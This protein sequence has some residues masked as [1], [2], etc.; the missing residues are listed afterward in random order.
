MVAW[1]GLITVAE[2]AAVRDR[3]AVEL[4]RRGAG[5]A[6]AVE[7]VGHLLRP[8]VVRAVL[9]RLLERGVALQ[10]RHLRRSREV[11][12]VAERV[13]LLVRVVSPWSTAAVWNWMNAS[14]ADV[15]RRAQ[16]AERVHRAGAA[17]VAVQERA[18]GVLDL[19]LAVVGA[20]EDRGAVDS[21]S[22]AA[23]IGQRGSS[24]RCTV[25]LVCLCRWECA[26]GARGDG[27]LTASSW[28]PPVAGLAGLL[29][30]LTA[31]A[32][33]AASPGRPRRRRRRRTGGGPSPAAPRFAA[34]PSAAR[35]P[36]TS[37]PC[38]SSCS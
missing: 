1:I 38:C 31:T 24:Y 3:L 37:S 16:R 36:R 8:L 6:A 33:P 2:P 7:R 19:V 13:D 21:C 12:G 20:L 32:T 34:R 29:A 18:E 35:A 30:W 15:Q 27:G 9:D 26:V 14:V 25:F 11:G 17:V 28:R 22:K 4:D 5:D 10:R 23:Q